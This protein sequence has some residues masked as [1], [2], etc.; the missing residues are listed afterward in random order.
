VHLVGFTIEIF[1]YKIT[2]YQGSTAK[3]SRLLRHT[4]STGIDPTSLNIRRGF[5][6]GNSHVEV[7]VAL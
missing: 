3:N 7:G 4:V 2:G 1:G 5:K 6:F